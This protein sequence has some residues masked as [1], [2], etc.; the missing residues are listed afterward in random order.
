MLVLSRKSDERIIIS[1]G[2][3]EIILTIVGVNKDSVRLG[4]TAPS[5]IKIDREEIHKRKQ[6][7]KQQQ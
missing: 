6:Y 1:D 7:G 5:H 2:T 4:F 3:T